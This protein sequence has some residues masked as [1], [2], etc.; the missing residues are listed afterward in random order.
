M[1][2]GQQFHPAEVVKGFRL[3]SPVAH[4]TVQRK[5]LMQMTHRVRIA[6]E[7]PAGDAGMAQRIGHAVF[8]P[9]GTEQ[10][11]RLVEVGKCLTVTAR[12]QVSH[13]HLVEGMRLTA[14]V[15]LGPVDRRGIFRQGQHCLVGPVCWPTSLRSSNACAI[16]PRSAMSRAA[17]RATVCA[18]IA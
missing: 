13:A 18:A 7:M 10:N 12:A 14:P 2:A 5:R 11:P 1:I 4:R 9:G 16:W 3:F 6:A 8:V 15:G 17:C